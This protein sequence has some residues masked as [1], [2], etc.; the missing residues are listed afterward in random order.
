MILVS[1]AFQT[2]IADKVLKRCEV[3]QNLLARDCLPLSKNVLSLIQ[4]RFSHWILRFA[5][6]PVCS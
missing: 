5:K 4:R 2:S 6:Q 1:R 3:R